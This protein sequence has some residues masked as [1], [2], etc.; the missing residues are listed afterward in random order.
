VEDVD[1]V[2]SDVDEI[3]SEV[4]DA[5]GFRHF[6]FARKKDESKSEE[7]KRLRVIHHIEARIESEGRHI[8]NEGVLQ[9]IEDEI[10]REMHRGEDEEKQKEHLIPSLVLL[11][12]QVDYMNQKNR[13]SDETNSGVKSGFYIH[14]ANYR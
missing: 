2:Q 1:Y 3:E 6:V 13:D 12:K 11:D 5:D 4:G 8:A 10:D 7:K 14:G 9:K